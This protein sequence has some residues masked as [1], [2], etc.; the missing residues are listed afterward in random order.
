MAEPEKVIA[1]RDPEGNVYLLPWYLVERGRVSDDDR[2]T[3]EEALDGE[4]E[5]FA[6]RY[7]NGKMLTT[8]DFSAEQS[9]LRGGR[10]FD[11][12][13]HLAKVSWSAE[14]GGTWPPT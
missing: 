10:V 1:F 9:Y 5:G 11:L 6:A 3:V 4:V 2:S 7:F 12:S 14:S 8:S 13:A